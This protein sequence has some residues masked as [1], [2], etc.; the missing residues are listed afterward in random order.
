M[1]ILVFILIAITAQAQFRKDI[2]SLSLGFVAGIADGGAES[3]KFHYDQVDARFNLND[4]Y[5]NPAVSWRN[6]YSRG[7]STMGP[8]FPGSTTYLVWTT[9]G[10]HMLRSVRNMTITG[11]IVLHPWS[12]KKWYWYVLE[13]VGHAVVYNL[14]FTIGYNLHKI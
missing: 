14:G 6:K 4:S 10:Y 7:L 2:P 8:K 13:L 12:K 1:R 9:D 11:A 5:W 3:L